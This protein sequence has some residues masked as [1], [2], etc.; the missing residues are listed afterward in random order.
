MII[1]EYG[2]WSAL[3]LHI[4]AGTSHIVTKQQLPRFIRECMI[5]S[6]VALLTV[7]LLDRRHEFGDHLNLV[8]EVSVG[9][10]LQSLT[11][12]QGATILCQLLDVHFVWLFKGF[13]CRIHEH[14]FRMDFNCF[15]RENTYKYLDVSMNHFGS[16]DIMFQFSSLFSEH[17]TLQ[18]VSQTYR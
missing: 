7:V 13:I 17:S 18:V 4:V 1:P 3:I 8:F 2:H 11:L 5:G 6:S 16:T 14:V 10:E 12:P 9:K 15:S